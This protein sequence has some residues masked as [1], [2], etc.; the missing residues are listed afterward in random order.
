MRR[1][2]L[3][4]GRPRWQSDL[5]ALPLSR[6]LRSWLQEPGSLTLRGQ[7]SF[8]RF[9]VSPVFEGLAR[10]QDGRMGRKCLPVREVVLLADGQPFIFAHS[11]LAGQSRG[12]LARWLKGLGSRSLGSLLF[13]LPGFQRGKLGFAQLDAR[14]ALYHLAGRQLSAAGLPVPAT[15]WARSCEHGFGQQSVRV[16]EVFIGPSLQD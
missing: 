7:N 8:S 1:F 11:V 10:P 15:L 2:G 13:R 16:T 9:T 14:D 3:G 5:P 4:R 12:V 6:E